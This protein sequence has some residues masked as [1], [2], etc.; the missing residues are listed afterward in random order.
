[1]ISTDTITRLEG[2]L[3]VAKAEQK[4]LVQAALDI[5][6]AAQAEIESVTARAEEAEAVAL[7][8]RPVIEAL[9]DEKDETETRLRNTEAA[10]QADKVRRS[11]EKRKA[12][13]DAEDEAALEA[14]VERFTQALAKSKDDIVTFFTALH[15][16]TRDADG[17]SVLRNFKKWSVFEVLD[18]VTN[19]IT[20]HES[21]ADTIK[22]VQSIIA[23]YQSTVTLEDLDTSKGTEDGSD[24]DARRS[25][26]HLG[27]VEPMPSDS[28]SGGRIDGKKLRKRVMRGTRIL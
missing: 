18:P 4:P 17:K 27:V 22:A 21:R 6:K 26:T 10:R 25:R 28:K 23:K 11:V 24:L 12:K 2:A 14:A 15:K 5:A 9:E 13:V 19:E 16:L 1:V 8:A 7:A 20:I 3:A